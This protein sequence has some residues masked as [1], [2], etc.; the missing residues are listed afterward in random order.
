M[1]PELI[2]PSIPCIFEIKSIRLSLL[3]YNLSILLYAAGIHVASIW[4]K[5][6][7]KWVKGR[8]KFPEL[9]FTKKTI[10]VHCASLGEFE[11]GRPALEAL[12]MEFPG[13]PVVLSFFSP[14]GYEVRKN[15]PG[16]DEIIYLPLDTSSNARKLVKMIN[17]A[18]VLWVKYEYWFHYLAELKKQEVPVVLVSGIFRKSQ[19]FF[20]WYGG[21]WRKMLDFFE[22]LFVQNEES[23]EL[24]RSLVHNDKINIG[25]DTR[26]DRV[27]AIA[28]N[29]EPVKLIPGFIGNYPVLVAGST[30]EDDEVELIHYVNQHPEIKFII[31]PHEID[32]INLQDVKKE[33]RNAVFYSDLEK[34]MQISKENNVLIIDNIGMLS[35]LYQYAD[36]TYIGGGFG[37]DGIHNTL[38]AA[39]YGKPVIFGPVYEK[40]AEARALVAAGGAFSINN[41]LELEKLLDSFFS[42]AVLKEKAG[43]ASGQYVYSMKGATQKII[44]YIKEKRLLIN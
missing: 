4:N 20:K 34:G 29:K 10:W 13:Y 16:A 7:G 42:N 41:A 37:S 2:K 22:Q 5:K 36:V 25:G 1:P 17:P 24:L 44:G 39:V 30:W 35:R 8:K 27:I 12:R 32:E 31:A 43:A 33:F 11:Q 9:H 21:I 3:F 15:Y 38:E 19:P 14:S 40:F 6:A 18:L 23:A 28:E 26:F